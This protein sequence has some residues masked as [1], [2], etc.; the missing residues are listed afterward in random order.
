ME[1]LLLQPYFIILSSS[2]A[3]LIWIVIKYRR[4]VDRKIH[5]LMCGVITLLGIMWFLSTPIISDII[6]RSLYLDPPTWQFRPDVIAV[7][8]GGYKLGFSFE[9]DAMGMET[10]LR[11]LT[12]LKLWKKYP[13][14]MMVMSGAGH[15]KRRKAKRQTD[16]MMEFAHNYGVPK[17]K[18]MA[19]TLSLNTREHPQRILELPSINKHTII[20]LVTSEWHMRRALFSFKQYFDEVYPS[21]I[22]TSIID[23]SLFAIQRFIPHPDALSKST[24]MIHEWIGLLW[25]KIK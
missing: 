1:K 9:Q 11:V 12:A 19:D 13:D 7:P 3:L 22:S 4:L 23:N 14:A 2:I 8:A 24:T 20:G 15:I 5:S 18:L 25:Y 6:E 21:P 17:A 16:L 10:N